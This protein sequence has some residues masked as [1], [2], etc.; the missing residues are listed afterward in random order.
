MPS[1][2]RDWL[3]ELPFKAQAVVLIGI[4]GCDS[5]AKFDPSKDLTT[6]LRFVALKPANRDT[7]T[8]MRKA[9]PDKVPNLDPYPHHW[10]THMMHAVQVVAYCHPDSDIRIQWQGIYNQ[11]CDELHMPPE[12][13]EEMLERL[14]GDLG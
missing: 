4:R 7:G 13:R 3:S 2:V 10:V 9:P 8:F 11:F 5:V 14:K 12:T 1:V 6:A